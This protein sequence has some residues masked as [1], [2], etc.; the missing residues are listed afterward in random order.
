[1]FKNEDAQT[2]HFL[3]IN[4]KV[5]SWP[6]ERNSLAAEMFGIW[7]IYNSASRPNHRGVQMKQ[8]GRTRRLAS[9]RQGLSEILLLMEEVQRRRN[10]SSSSRDRW[11]MRR[12]K[13][14]RGAVTLWTVAAVKPDRGRRRGRDESSELK[15]RSIR[16][17]SSQW[18]CHKEGAH[19]V[20]LLAQKHF[21]CPKFTN[22]YG[23]KA[24]HDAAYQP[25]LLFSVSLKLVVLTALCSFDLLTCCYAAITQKL[26]RGV[27]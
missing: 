22:Q 8:P 17:P 4:S 6:R 2:W 13:N 10:R 5:V 14:W 3:T 26:A 27:S 9:T 19:H 1:M 20:R 21:S 23:V 11:K 18:P 25:L 16:S 15:V 12:N 24:E 7:R